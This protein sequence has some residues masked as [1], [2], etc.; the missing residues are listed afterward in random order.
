MTR[1][2]IP[3]DEYLTIQIASFIH[4]VDSKSS[5]SSKISILKGCEDELC[6]SISWKEDVC[7][8]KRFK[9]SS[10]IYLQNNG[11][12]INIFLW[13]AKARITNRFQK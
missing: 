3:S 2:F 5:L 1:V 4:D 9:L 6:T 7:N 10:F 13:S 11:E 12:E 8:E